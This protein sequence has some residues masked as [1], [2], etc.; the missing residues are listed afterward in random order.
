MVA[1]VCK[2]R[3][4][5]LFVR[6]SSVMN[7][8]KVTAFITR[9]QGP[10]TE[11]LIFRHPLAG[12]QLPAGTVEAGETP[13]D[14]A[15]REGREET[16]L[17]GLVAVRELAVIS[18]LVSPADRMLLVDSPLYAEPS[19]AS[20]TV[21]IDFGGGVMIDRLRRGLW[22]RALSE[23]SDWMHAAYDTFE[24]SQGALEL[25]GSTS[26]WLP[27]DACA[28]DVGRSLW[29]LACNEPALD[30]WTHTEDPG[31]PVIHK[32]GME[33]FW[34]RLSEDIVLAGAQ[35]DWLTAARPHLR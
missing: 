5:I 20:A 16:G 22:V 23:T 25:S 18:A 11:L 9:G 24:W 31:S 33:L 17:A 21:A 35:A 8:H 13:V 15:L 26:G 29:H 7:I 10:E 14:A 28:A 3:G 27:S 2:H 6:L 1:A 4:R 19:T 34:A 32:M 30:A 12:P